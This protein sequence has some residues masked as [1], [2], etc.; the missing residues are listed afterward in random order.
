VAKLCEKLKRLHIT[1]CHYG[2]DDWCYGG[3]T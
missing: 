1:I 2:V 3:D